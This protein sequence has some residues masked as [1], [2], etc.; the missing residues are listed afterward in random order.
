MQTCFNFVNDRFTS[1]NFLHHVYTSMVVRMIVLYSYRTPACLLFS[2][3]HIAL[4]AFFLSTIQLSLTPVNSSQRSLGSQTWF[5]LLET[6]IDDFTLKGISHRLPLA[7]SLRGHSNPHTFYK[8]F[9][10]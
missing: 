4:S 5:D 7:L 10:P 6:E 1:L 8:A 9:A 2:P 3:H